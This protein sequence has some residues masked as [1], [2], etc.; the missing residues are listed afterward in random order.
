VLTDLTVDGADPIAIRV[1][2]VLV[3]RGPRPPHSPPRTP[4]FA[5]DITVRDPAT[6]ALRAC[7]VL[8]DGKIMRHSFT[9]S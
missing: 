5:L 9:V 8:I 3:D 6:K 1:K 7:E 4:C 2:E